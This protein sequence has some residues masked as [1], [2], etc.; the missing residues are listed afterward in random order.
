MNRRRSKYT[1]EIFLIGSSRSK[2]L[3]TYVGLNQYCFFP[4]QSLAQNLQ[5]VVPAP[6]GIWPL[7]KALG[8]TDVS[9]NKIP[10]N[11]SWIAYD[12][13]YVPSGITGSPMFTKELNHG[14]FIQLF[15]ASK[16][17]SPGT[18]IIKLYSLECI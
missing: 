8:P 18:M 6:A 11:E 15:P 5:P 10:G 16:V 1:Q 7:S 12:P 2:T 14:S 9:S 17:T 4:E 3:K 13:L